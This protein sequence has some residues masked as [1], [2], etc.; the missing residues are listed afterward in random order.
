MK[1]NILLIASGSFMALHGVS[2]VAQE[3]QTEATVETETKTG[4]PTA[5]GEGA[6]VTRE[7][8]TTTTTAD[9]GEVSTDTAA[10]QTVEMPA[11]NA[12]VVARIKDEDG[13]TKTTV[14][15]S[16]MDHSGHDMDDSEES[17]PEPEAN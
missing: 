13:K 6:V 15:H 11:G 4:D 2:A 12:T 9:T 1:K 3:T 17:D 14:D 7:T 10:T 8:T 16:K 5:M